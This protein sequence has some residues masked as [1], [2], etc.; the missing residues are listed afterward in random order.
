MMHFEGLLS[1][2]I[3]PKGLAIATRKEASKWQ[4]GKS[5]TYWSYLLGST[6]MHIGDTCNSANGKEHLN[7][8]GLPQG[9]RLFL[10]EVAFR[11]LI[12]NELYSFQIV[13]VKSAA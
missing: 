8:L 2:G 9:V 13:V 12:T 10:T 1:G 6:T 7:R 5:R 11:V 3:L 4:R